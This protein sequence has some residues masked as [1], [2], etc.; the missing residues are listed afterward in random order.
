[1]VT[2]ILGERWQGTEPIIQLLAIIGILG[3]VT[4]IVVPAFKGLGYPFKFALIEGAQSLLLVLFIYL[5][6]PSWGL[7]GA[8]L[9]WFPAIF[10]SLLVAVFYLHRI[11]PHPFA[12]LKRPML[13]MMMAALSGGAVA[14]AV[15]QNLPT[16]A[17]FILAGL[18]AVAVIV[19]LTWLFD[20]RFKLGIGRSL[21][22]LFPQVFDFLQVQRQNNWRRGSSSH[23]WWQLHR[24]L[25]PLRRFVLRHLYRD[26]NRQLQ[27]S[28]L[29]AGT[30]RSGTT[31]LGD[32]VAGTNGRILFEPFHAHKIPALHHLP[33][34]PYLRP[35]EENSQLSA[36]C[37]QVFSGA[38]RHPW[39][40]REVSHLHPNYRIIKEIRANLML[41]WLQVHFPQ[42]PQLFIVRHPCAVVLS[43]LQLHWATDSDLHAFLQQQSLMDDFLMPYLHI[44]EQAQTEAEKHAVI[45]C[46]SHLV[47]LRQFEPEELNLVFYEDLCRYPKR[48]LA[49]IEQLIKRPLPPQTLASMMT[50]SATTIISSAV[51]TGDNRVT[52]WQEKLSAPEIKQV[53]TIV[54]AFNLDY[55]YGNS[56]WP[57][58]TSTEETC[59]DIA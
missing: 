54:A 28:I 26:D 46:I 48:E 36:Y 30:A 56:P 58:A 16:F 31:W 1:L 3:L 7:I 23:L 59:F 27:A 17:G 25:R 5:F 34:F 43:R 51:L 55:L 53:L 41:K 22:I 40:D 49:R 52:Q 14:A 39:I 9:A 12:G 57:Q 11:L 38:I 50:P 37:N 19:G 29:V 2:H 44:I 15:Y 8:P 35:G 13:A 6:I 47:P 21:V 33:Y 18:L 42:I 45:W 4:D 10:G 20:Q 32:I 24:L